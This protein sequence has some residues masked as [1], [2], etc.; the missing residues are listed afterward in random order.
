[1]RTILLSYSVGP[2][3]F[4]TGCATIIHGTKEHVSVS[5]SPTAAQILVKGVP[6][7]TSPSVIELKRKDPGI[8]LRIEKEG[9][10]PGEII[11]NRKYSGWL[12]GNLALPMAGIFGGA[13]DFSTG[14]AYKLV[15]SAVYV[16]LQKQEIEEESLPR[17]DIREVVRPD[18]LAVRKKERD[19]LTPSQKEQKR[20]SYGYGISGLYLIFPVPFIEGTVR[21]G[22]VS[23][24][25]NIGSNLAYTEARLELALFDRFYLYD[26][27]NIAVQVD[28]QIDVFGIG[29]IF[30]IG[31]DMAAADH[32]KYFRFELGFLEWED[33]GRSFEI[34]RVGMGWRF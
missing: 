28:E 24:R 34:P 3:V 16:E 27:A 13:I 33:G 23:L 4:L 21:V 9:Y 32:R 11:I 30:G 2:L 6:V 19:T 10:E 26:G 5:S 17:Q 22:A 31:M 18:S 8:V 20:F 12:A 1:M 25:G 7:A 29:D 15:P 14:A